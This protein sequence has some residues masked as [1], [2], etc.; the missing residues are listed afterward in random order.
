MKRELRTRASRPG[1]PKNVKTLSWVSF[2]QDA[3]SEML[4][5][6]MP[7]FITAVLGAPVAVLGLI[8]GVAEGTAAVTKAW[9]GRLSDRYRRRPLIVAGYTMSSISKPMIGLATGWPLVLA[10]RFTDRLGK[11]VRT[12]PRDALI[13]AD[14]PLE[15]RGRAFGFHRAADTAGAVVGPL[16]GLALYELLDHDLRLLFFVAFVPA[17]ISVGLIFLVHERPKTAT[18]VTQAETR[19][20]DAGPAPTP[21]VARPRLPA[22]YRRTVAVLAVFGL[23]NF[24]DA[25]LILRA[26]Q[27]GLGFASIML[28][29]VAYNASYALLSYP[30]GA[31][32]DRVPRRLVF[33]AGLV[34]FAIAYVG[35]GLIDNA[36]WVWLLL[37]LYGAYTALTDGVAK[38][39]VSDWLSQD[40]LGTGLGN[41]QAITGVCSLAAGIWAGLAWGGSGS[42]PL[43]LAGCVAG[44][45]A[46]ALIPM[47]GLDVRR[48]PVVGPAGGGGLRAG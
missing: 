23:V 38:A 12:S 11:G 14:T 10:A 19:G 15:I 21:A 16:I 24:S 31:L 48:K 4:Y 1:I 30:A 8:E 37:P 17:A 2:F 46:V 9:S 41:F 39:W 47:R 7:L 32:S 20:P 44:V 29:Y 40:R 18:A 22:G 3:S 35:L 13:A 28:V 27:L 26:D 45:L 33:A 42:L 5:P 34:V 25:F 36:A 43:V 6:V